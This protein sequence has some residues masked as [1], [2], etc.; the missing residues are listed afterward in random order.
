MNVLSPSNELDWVLL[1]INYTRQN[2]RIDSTRDAKTNYN[3]NSKEK[4]SPLIGEKR[5]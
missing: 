2:L 5:K 1:Y 4:S 3:V